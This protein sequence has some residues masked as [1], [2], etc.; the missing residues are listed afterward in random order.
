MA[1]FAKT[2]TGRFKKTA[3][4]RCAYCIPM[5]VL[6]ASIKSEHVRE[7]D[8][9]DRHKSYVS[10]DDGADCPLWAPRALK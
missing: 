1:E 8:Y 7:P 6:P 4:S 5:P 2:P 10:A 9:L 3:H